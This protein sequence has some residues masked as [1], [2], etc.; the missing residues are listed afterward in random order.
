M[1]ATDT[2]TAVKY[3]EELNPSIYWFKKN[4]IPKMPGLPTVPFACCPQPNGQTIKCLVS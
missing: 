4:Y 3:K 2:N 1:K